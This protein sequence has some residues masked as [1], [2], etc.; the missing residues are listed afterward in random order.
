MPDDAAL[1]YAYAFLRVIAFSAL[2]AAAGT[3]ALR[4]CFHLRH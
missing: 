4:C 2:A 1:R 3:A